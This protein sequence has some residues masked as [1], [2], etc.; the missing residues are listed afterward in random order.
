MIYREYADYVQDI[1]DAID[2]I[3]RIVHNK[4][5]EEFENTETIY[6]TVERMFEVIGEASNRI[7]IIIQ[8]EY[9]ELSKYLEEMPVTIP[10][11]K[12]SEIN[13]K[14]LMKFIVDVFN[15]LPP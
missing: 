2:T 14:K 5:Y 10:N 7:P 13:L 1:L 12:T 15:R 3:N 8:E 11:A 9:P 4:T 6:Y